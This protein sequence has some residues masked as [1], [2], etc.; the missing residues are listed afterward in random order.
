MKKLGLIGKDIEYSFSKQYFSTKFEKEGISDWSYELYSFNHI[1][2]LPK[3]LKSDPLLVGLNVT[4]PFKKDVLKYLHQVEETALKIGAVNTISIADDQLL[5]Y[6]TDI[7]GFKK[8]LMDFVGDKITDLK[9]LVLGTGGASQAIIFVLE[10]LGIP[11]QLISRSA[12]KGLT[13]ASLDKEIILSHPL[14]I[15][16]TPLGTY[17]KVDE[18]VDIPYSHL[19]G[20]HFLFDLVYNPQKSLFLQRGEKHGAN[21]LNG[22]KM[23]EI[24]AEEAW[25]IWIKTNI[26]R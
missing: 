6:N 21:I 18:A 26:S 14:I 25:K 5:G 16:C 7:L 13:Y 17:P 15:N 11:Y 23:L 1:N 24:Q 19:S 12:S 9:S 8:S 4:I 2:Q 20:E 3:L 10:E 22:Y